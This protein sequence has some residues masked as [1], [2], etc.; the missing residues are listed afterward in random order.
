MRKILH[1]IDTTGPGGAETVFLMLSQYTIE[2]DNYNSVA[3]VSGKGWVE[4]MLSPHGMK[5]YIINSKGSFN[6]DYLKQ[7]IRLV[8]NEKIDVIHAHLFGPSIYCSVASIVTNTRL[9]CTI[10]GIVDISPHERFRCVKMGLLGIGSNYVV[11][12]NSE[13]EKKM[14]K[15]KLIPSKKIVTIYN[16]IDTNSFEYNGSDRC[17]KVLSVKKNEILIGSLGNIRGPKN[18]DLA[19]R[20]INELHI[21]GY[22]VHYCIAGQGSDAQINQLWKL[23]ER[24]NLKN[25]IHILGF[26]DDVQSFLSNLDVLL[27]SSFSEGHPLSVMQA[28]ANGVPVVSTPNG[29]EKI[30]KSDFEI[31]ISKNYD[32]DSL[33]TL[34]IEQIEQGRYNNMTENAKK[35]VQKKYS[36]TTMFN[37]YDSL[38]RGSIQKEG[39]FR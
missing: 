33:A 14:Q 30:F 36:R 8:K 17:R 29:V 12:V 10:H 13:I 31:A 32:A 6:H 4:S 38:Y 9:I 1:V 37:A 16:G 3:L 18:Y 11:C 20:V 25:Y 27:M 7:L 24:F 15:E 22:Y 23:I 35:R 19:I 5:T 26:V 34:L 2:N 39:D 28:M 21:A